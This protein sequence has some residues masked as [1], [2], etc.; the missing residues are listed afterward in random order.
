M[1]DCI[2]HTY[3]HFR[4]TWS[5]YHV[6]LKTLESRNRMPST[7]HLCR[8]SLLLPEHFQHILWKLRLSELD[9]SL[10]HHAP[11]RKHFDPRFVFANSDS[12]FSQTLWISAAQLMNLVRSSG[13]AWLHNRRARSLRLELRVNVSNY[14][15]SIR[16]AHPYCEILLWQQRNYQTDKSPARKQP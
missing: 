4:P 10:R 6:S 12:P 2:H 13:R 5:L 7:A 11:K 15:S 8:S 14:I 1:H 3:F 9:S 16:S